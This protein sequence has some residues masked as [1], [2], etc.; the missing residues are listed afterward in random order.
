MFFFFFDKLKRRSTRENRQFRGMS[1]KSGGDGFDE[2]KYDELL[3]HQQQQLHYQRKDVDELPE[4]FLFFLF[5]FIII[6]LCAL[7]QQLKS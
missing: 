1:K 5:H 6:V 7:H 2:I 3:P 4:N